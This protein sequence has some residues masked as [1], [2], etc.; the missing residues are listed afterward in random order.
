MPPEA[1]APYAEGVGGVGAVAP[2]ARVG[3]TLAKSAVVLSRC[4]TFCMA[5]SYRVASVNGPGMHVASNWYT[6]A[7]IGWWDWA[8]MEA[9]RWRVSNHGKWHRCL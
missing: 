8:H 7:R 5:C 9:R 6:R 2:A 1:G 4:S 3:P